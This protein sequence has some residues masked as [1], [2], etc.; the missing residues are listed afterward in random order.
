MSH[1]C[2]FFDEPHLYGR[3]WAGGALQYP[4][5]YPIADYISRYVYCL[6][7]RRLTMMPVGQALTVKVRNEERETVYAG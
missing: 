7:A 4:P 2:L 3:G 5:Q 1:R 6:N